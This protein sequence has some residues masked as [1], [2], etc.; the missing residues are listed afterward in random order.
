MLSNP[1]A[2][3]VPWRGAECYTVTLPPRNFVPLRVN[4]IYK[5]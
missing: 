2:D 5:L 1:A 4:L 3:T